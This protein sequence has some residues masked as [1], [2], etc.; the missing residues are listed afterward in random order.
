MIHLLGR[1]VGRNCESK[2][3]SNPA[4]SE[5]GEGGR[6]GDEEGGDPGWQTKGM[7]FRNITRGTF[8]DVRVQ[9]RPQESSSRWQLRSAGSFIAEIAGAQYTR[10]WFSRKLTPSFQMHKRTKMMGAECVW[11]R[12][13]GLNLTFI[14][15]LKQTVSLNIK[16]QEYIYYFF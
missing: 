15:I 7:G 9:T 6:S 13:L 14:F 8:S 16:H 10:Q 12:N 4:W 3:R 5:S 2:E 11:M 1:V